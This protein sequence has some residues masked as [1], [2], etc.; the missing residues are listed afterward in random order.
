MGSVHPSKIGISFGVSN[1]SRQ[2]GIAFGIAFLGALLTNRF[3][4]YI[5]DKI[6]SLSVPGLSSVSKHDI[7]TGTQKAGTIDIL[8]I[9]G[10][11]LK[12]GA[13]VS[14]ILIRDRD[15]FHFQRGE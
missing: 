5:H 9:A 8:T 2:I 7:I 11:I 4:I 1:V 13:V 12:V 14:I 6:T 10:C 15:M 3:N